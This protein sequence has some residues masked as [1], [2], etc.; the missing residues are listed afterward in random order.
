MSDTGYPAPGGGPAVAP[1]DQKAVWALVCSIA[2]F[3]ICPVI[4]HV[5]GLILAN[6]S[7]E[8]IAASRGQL[9]GE[10]LAK[11]AR[12]LSIIGLVLAAI[13]VL[14]WLLVFVFAASQS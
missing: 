10:G 6:Q 7:L 5:A 4:L 1:T 8:A 13:G 14:V 11:T 9:A 2:G 12:I 3:V